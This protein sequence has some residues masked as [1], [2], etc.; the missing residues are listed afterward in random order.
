MSTYVLDTSVVIKW[1]NQKNELHTRQ[2]RKIFD[3]L[4]SEKINILIPDLLL[5]ELLNALMIGKKTPIEEA[6]L[7]VKTL[8]AST[9]NIV[10]LTLPVL[11]QTSLVI[12][13]YNLTS[14]DAYF[15]ALAQYEK[16]TLVSDDQKAHGKIDSVMMLKDYR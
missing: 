9:I 6:N 5:V 4:Q 3:D 7:A 16:C 10:E 2:A 12:K 15:L 11:L 14:Y 1:F 13:Q 8:F